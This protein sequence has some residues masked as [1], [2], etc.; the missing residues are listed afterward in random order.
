MHV[1]RRT[2]YRLT[3]NLKKHHDGFSATP[4]AARKLFSINDFK[5]FG[6]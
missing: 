3:P 1:Q 4:Q 2:P 6:P 5:R